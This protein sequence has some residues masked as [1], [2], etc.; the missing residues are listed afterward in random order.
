MDSKDIL[1]KVKSEG[2]TK[3]VK[4]NELN[5]YVM[6]LKSTVRGSRKIK[7]NFAFLQFSFQGTIK[8][9]NLLE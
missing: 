4:F 2:A 7:T 8:I 9:Q 6:Q 3:P 5:I 1:G